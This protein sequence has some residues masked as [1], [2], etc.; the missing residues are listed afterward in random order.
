MAG[1]PFLRA[2]A[3]LGV[4]A[5]CAG[6]AAWAAWPRIAALTGIGAGNPLNREV[7]IAFVANP[8]K[9]DPW[10]FRP[11]EQDMRL[12]LGE[13]GIAFYKAE[14][15]TARPV[16]GQAH[17]SVE[18]AAADKYLVRIACFCTKAQALG[19]HETIEMPVTFY[20]DPSIASDPAL[21]HL[22]KITLSYTFQEAKTPVRQAAVAVPA[23]TFN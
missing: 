17:Y 22:K 20:V 9:G 4:V 3:A 1:G 16:S 12:R 11:M 23:A 7:T 13:T 6:A 15:T 10:H 2:M 8:G 19:P 18:P 5:I 14:N 21:K